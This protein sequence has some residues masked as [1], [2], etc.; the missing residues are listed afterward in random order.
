MST[1][2]ENLAKIRLVVSEISLL[3]VIAKKEEE[4]MGKKV[5]AA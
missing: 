4:R 3:Q 5:T 1:I 2:P